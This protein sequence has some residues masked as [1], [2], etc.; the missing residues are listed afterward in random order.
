MFLVHLLVALNVFDACRIW[1]RHTEFSSAALGQC[2]KPNSLDYRSV[3][4][5]SNG[6]ESR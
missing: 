1:K 3:K 4:I 5:D 2:E 6:A